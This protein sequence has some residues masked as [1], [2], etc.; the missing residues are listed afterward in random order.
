VAAS[1]VIN[2]CA[3]LYFGNSQLC[4]AQACPSEKWLIVGTRIKDFKF[5][6]G[7]GD[8]CWFVECKSYLVVL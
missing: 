3:I 1:D 8:L 2:N 4:F 6:S 7:R 5:C